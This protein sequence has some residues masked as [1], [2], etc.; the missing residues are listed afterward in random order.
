MSAFQLVLKA[1]AAVISLVSIL[2]IVLGTKAELLLGAQWP[3]GLPFDAV[4]DSQDR[5]YGAAFSIFACLLW[6]SANDLRR[7]APLLKAMLA[8]F[9]LG[10]VARLISCAAVGQPS[11]MIYFLWAVEIIVPPALWVWMQRRLALLPSV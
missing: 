6:R 5:F 2:H 3:R 8:V 4:L 1:F 7:Y 11:A 9:F 10:A